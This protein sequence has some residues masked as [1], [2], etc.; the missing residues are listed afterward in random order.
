MDEASFPLISVS[1]S[2]VPVLFFSHWPFLANGSNAENR[3]NGLT[4]VPTGPEMVFIMGSLMPPT[5]RGRV[6]FDG[7]GEESS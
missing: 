7:L 4:V 3:I 6:L 1:N 2:K 5:G